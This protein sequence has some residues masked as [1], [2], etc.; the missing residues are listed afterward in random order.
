MTS[1]NCLQIC[2]YEPVTGIH[3]VMHLRMQSFFICFGHW[4]S[5]SLLTRFSTFSPDSPL[6]GQTRR[7]RFKLLHVLVVPIYL[8]TSWE[9]LHRTQVFASSNMQKLA[10][11]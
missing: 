2:A 5:Q 9:K 3:V 1:Q 6:H 7:L 11:T 10:R 8:W 4:Q